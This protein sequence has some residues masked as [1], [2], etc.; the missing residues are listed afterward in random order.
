MNA[1]SRL[2]TAPSTVVSGP[3]APHDPKQILLREMRRGVEAWKRSPIEIPPRLR[4]PTAPPGLESVNWDAMHDQFMQAVGGDD[5]VQPSD[6]TAAVNLLR[7]SL[8][9]PGTHLDLARLDIDILDAAVDLVAQLMSARANTYPPVKHLTLPGG[10]EVLPRWL[11]AFAPSL[12]SL[13]LPDYYDAASPEQMHTQADLTRFSSLHHVVLID[14]QDNGHFNVDRPLPA[15]CNVVQTSLNMDG[16]FDQRAALLRQ[17]PAS[18][19]C[20]LDDVLAQWMIGIGAVDL[21][22]SDPTDLETLA[23][24]GVM[25]R[26]VALGAASN[27]VDVTALTLPKGMTRLPDWVLELKGLAT[28][29]AGSIPPKELDVRA[30]K[31][32]RSLQTL[33]PSTVGARLPAGCRLLWASQKV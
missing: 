9:H 22:A 16:Y 6:V 12:Q 21:S 25:D 2:N 27:P 24:C 14:H 33:G 23:E 32:L 8:E 31:Q 3:Q 7:T 4:T 18:A 11:H 30:L 26:I 13:H 17:A 19:L 5:E 10:L 1:H 20:T 28:L 29:D 15:G